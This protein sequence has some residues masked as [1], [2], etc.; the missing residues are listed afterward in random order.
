MPT[1]EWAWQRSLCPSMAHSLFP[2][3]QLLEWRAVAWTTACGRLR[4]GDSTGDS[5]MKQSTNGDAPVSRQRLIELLN[6]DLSREYQAI[7][8][9]VVYSRDKSSLSNSISRWRDTGASP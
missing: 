3:R 9:Y 8:A 5:I 2:A 6:E 7:I 1:I 4:R